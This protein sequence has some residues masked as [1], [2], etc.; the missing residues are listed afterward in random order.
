MQSEAIKKKEEKSLRNW[1]ISKKLIRYKLHLSHYSIVKQ[2]PVFQ[3]VNNFITT[4]Q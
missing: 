3:K 1:L 2:D 4:I